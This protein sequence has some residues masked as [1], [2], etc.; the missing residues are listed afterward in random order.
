MARWRIQ[1]WN[2][3][4]LFYKFAFVIL[5]VGLLPVLVLTGFIFQILLTRYEDTLK[6]NYEQVA[7]HISTNLENTIDS[8]NTISK[9]IYNYS[10]ATDNLQYLNYLNADKF[11]QVIEQE[12]AKT[13]INSFLR[14]VQSAD[15]YIY[16][17]HFLGVNS[18][19][20]K[21]DY[22]YSMTSNYFKSID[23]Y[24]NDVNYSNW[25]KESKNLQVVKTHKN[26]YFNGMEKEI[27]TFGRNYFDIRGDIG[28]SKYVG[29]IF[30]DVDIERLVMLLSDVKVSSEV[31][32][33]IVNER[34]DCFF[35]NN[36]EAIRENLKD[37]PMSLE[38]SSEQ[39]VINS[40]VN[41]YGL[42]VIV[43]IN[44]NTAFMQIRLL[45]KM[46]ISAVL[47]STAILLLGSIWFSKRLTRPI[48]NMVD[49]MQLIE[50][51]NFDLQLPVTSDD[52]IGILSARFNQ[53]LTT[54]NQYINQCYVAKIK[55]NEA[56]LT[57][58]KSQIYPHFL[59]NTLEVIRMTAVENEDEKVSKMIQAL[60]LQ[61]RYIIGNA[62][63]TVPLS[64]EITMIENYVYLLNCRIEHSFLF[65][66]NAPNSKE[67]MVP[68]LI[69]QPIIE[70][71]YV[72]GLKPKGKG[73]NITVDVEKQDDKIIISIMDNGVGMN[74]MQVEKIRKMLMGNDMGIR[75][76][77]NW[78]SIGVKNVHDRIRYLYGADFGVEIT[79][80]QAV[81]TMVQLFIP[82]RKECE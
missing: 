25:D 10:S 81:G 3:K 38:N 60:S 55:Q 22:H 20:K 62:S 26:R 34:E 63:D 77:Y 47:F 1:L 54:L 72:H 36:N 28:D 53:M 17:T 61:M 43:I 57:A 51:G 79:S 37:Y 66:V 68:K 71:A 65:H 7:T 11:R 73:G 2:R 14:N 6:N 80:S 64:E 4:S 15:S 59:C 69:L 52:E 41:K 21:I 29:T 49:S 13:K 39:L 78:Q 24:E 74:E 8:Y 50:N 23:I 12:D 16:A 33:Y 18:E 75:N 82:D 67:I 44:K 45:Q 32:Y 40:N 56:E 19:G 42:K 31:T 30:I 35:S 46:L 58:L 5:V 27:I 48:N 9:M 76:E 70:N